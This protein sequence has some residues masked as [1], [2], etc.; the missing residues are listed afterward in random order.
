MIKTVSQAR[1]SKKIISLS[2][3]EYRRLRQESQ[4]YRTLA[5]RV[6]EIP[7]RDPIED[8]VSDF[9]ATELYSDQFLSDLEEGL[10]KSSYAHRHA[11][12]IA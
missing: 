4:A 2:E 9:R 6:F 5:A 3:G 7:L 11:D 10:R 1:R 12:K 8:V